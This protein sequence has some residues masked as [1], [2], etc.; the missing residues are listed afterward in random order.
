VENFAKKPSEIDFLKKYSQA[1]TEEER[2]RLE[3]EFDAEVNAYWEWMDNAGKKKE[4]GED[5]DGK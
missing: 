2:T 3:E 1:K 5:D 4:G